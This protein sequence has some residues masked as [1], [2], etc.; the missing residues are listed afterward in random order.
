MKYD[1]DKPVDRSNTN[2][3]KWDRNKEFL[4]SADV[5]PLW[6]ADM[7]LECC[8]KIVKAIHQRLE[9]KIFGYSYRPDSFY[10]AIIDWN[11]KRFNW[12]I[13]KD[14]ILNTPGVVTAIA[15]ALQTFSQK[16]DQV[17][18]QPP[19]YGPFHE[20]VELNERKLIKNN[21]LLKNNRYYLDF[22]DLEEKF[23]QGVKMMLLCSPHNPVSRVWTKNE[24]QKIGKL[25]RKYDVLIVSDE[26]HYDFVLSEVQ[27]YPIANL[28]TDFTEKTITLTAPSK[29]FNLAG[30][31]MAN[32]II[33]NNN[34]REKFYESVEKLHLSNSTILGM[35]AEEAAYKYGEEWLEQVL[36]YVKKN[37]RFVKTYIGNNLPKIK[38]IKGEGTFLLWLDFREFDLAHEELK[39]LIINKA[40]VGLFEGKFFGKSGEGFF[41]MNLAVSRKVLA[42][43]L[44]QLR[45]VL[46]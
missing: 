35:V 17:L 24:L 9:H 31:K 13:K 11:K 5:I 16:G 15:I 6:V 3:F 25:A 12:E 32:V 44:D 29:T 26:I 28:S 21:L 18:I 38:V 39:E 2:S 46:Q 27:H 14:W 42:M 8:Q 37:R 34:I 33:S 43:A 19:V 7:D 20:V 41:R 22:N 36:E 40:K 23:A 45:E 1:F 10:K 4:G 30:F